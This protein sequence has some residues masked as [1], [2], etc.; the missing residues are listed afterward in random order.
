MRRPRLTYANVMSTIAVFLALGGTSYAIARNSIG[1]REL[2]D[3]AVT[4]RK[5]RDGALQAQ[6]LAPG[7]LTQGARGPRGSQGP[8]GAVGPAGPQGP[9]GPAQAETWKPFPF[10]AGWTNY[11][12]I[13]F[14]PGAF[15]KDQL[16]TVHL[17]G[18]VTLATG[19]PATT[20]LIGTLP[21]GY[22]PSNT[23]VF[24][25]HT[26]HPGASGRV[27][28]GTD[29]RVSWVVGANTQEK[30]YTSLTGISFATD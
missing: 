30:D 9:A 25:V 18:L 19:Q 6:D 2:K 28:V 11:D 16:G 10:A 27:D 7:A 14:T 13:A 15:R 17:R 1:E 24:V 8:V 29:G 4:S 22:R 23:L 21:T 20:A 26:G 5:V 3:S 12:D